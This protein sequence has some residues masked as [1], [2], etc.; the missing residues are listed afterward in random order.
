M[1]ITPWKFI[2]LKDEFLMFFLD[3]IVLEHFLS[4]ALHSQ[5]CTLKNDILILII[6]N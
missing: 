5:I 3:Q 6:L 1:I 4:Q 2:K